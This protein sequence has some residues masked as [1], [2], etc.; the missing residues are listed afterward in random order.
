M[1]S[2]LPLVPR[3]EEGLVRSAFPSE[4]RLSRVFT[5]VTLRGDN[6][7]NGSRM[8]FS[9]DLTDFSFSAKEKATLLDHSP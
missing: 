8:A 3:A 5:N 4:V 2:W 1:G 6:G 7:A 9:R